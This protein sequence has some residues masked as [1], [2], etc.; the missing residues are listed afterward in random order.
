MSG[1]G[2]LEGTTNRF[3]GGN[4]F[5]VDQFEFVGIGFRRDKNSEVKGME[6]A[7]VASGNCS[8]ASR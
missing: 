3:V 7:K 8:V 5:G 1:F 4:N 2:K 6:G